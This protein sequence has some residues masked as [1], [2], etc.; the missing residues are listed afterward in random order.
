[1]TNT[2]TS[3]SNDLREQVWSIAVSVEWT[4][5]DWRDF[6]ESLTLVFT[7]IAAR[8]AKSKIDAVGK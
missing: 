3:M 1:M 7:R 5:A 4:E 8:H 6:Y 2:I